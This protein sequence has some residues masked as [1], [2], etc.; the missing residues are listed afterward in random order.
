MPDRTRLV[1]EYV[2]LVLGSALA[3]YLYPDAMSQAN[4]PT[5]DMASKIVYVLCHL[6]VICGLSLAM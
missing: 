4:L 1:I 5:R 3:L 2:T 6:W